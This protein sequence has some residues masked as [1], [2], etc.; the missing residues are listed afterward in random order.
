MAM[1]HGRNRFSF[2]ERATGRVTPI[3]AKGSPEVG[4]RNEPVRRNTHLRK[5]QPLM[6]SM[7]AP[8]RSGYVEVDGTQLYYETHG[9]GPAI[10][11]IHG[12]FGS[13]NQFA[14]A[15]RWLA[16]DHMCVLVDL[17]GHGRTAD[18]AQPLR[19]ERL[20]DDCAAVLAHLNVSRCAVIGFSMGGGTAQQLAIRHS[21]LVTKLVVVSA[22]FSHHGWH[23]D[24]MANFRNTGSH[25][26]PDVMDSFIFHDHAALAPKPEEFPVLLDK[27]G[28]L[29]GHHEYDWSA[30]L[31][32]LAIP[33]LI[34]VGDADSLSPTHAAEFF[35]LLGGGTRDAG[36]GADARPASELAVLPR[37]T[38]YDILH[39]E[40]MWT[41]AAAFLQRF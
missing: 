2:V 35:R 38:H 28:D 27:L 23:A 21:R 4:E 16:N 24:V 25:Q 9:S 15:L 7:P 17:Q 33:V 26:A 3:Y 10:M 14:E 11:L 18:R 32:S 39:S 8:D 34:A 30:E 19:Y 5:R 37:T 36:F 29:L 40:L 13:G 22:P 20:A 12:A 1:R 31:S 6:S 41:C